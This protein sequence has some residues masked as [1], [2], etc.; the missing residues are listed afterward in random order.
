MPKSPRKTWSRWRKSPKLI[1]P[2]LFNEYLKF[3]LKCNEIIMN[4]CIYP[5]EVFYRAMDGFVATLASLTLNSQAYLTPAVP[6]RK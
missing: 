4:F 1:S 2:L 6:A 5:L 3:E